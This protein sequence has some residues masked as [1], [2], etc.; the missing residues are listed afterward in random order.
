MNYDYAR[1]W[2]F[3]D[4]CE[5]GVG[6]PLVVRSFPFRWFRSS[7]LESDLDQMYS[8]V[9]LVSDLGA[10]PSCPLCHLIG[11]IGRCASNVPAHSSNV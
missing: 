7:K 5:R 2:V 1:A 9:S 6:C 11:T 3:L 8:D 10:L 4:G